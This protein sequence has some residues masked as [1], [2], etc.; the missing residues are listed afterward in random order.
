MTVATD[1]DDLQ[2]TLMIPGPIRLS[3]DV[4]NALG[5]PSISHTG[6]HFTKTF[7]SALLK[8]QKLFNVEEKEG[9]LP[10]VISSSGTMGWD[11]VGNNLL[12][13]SDTDCN[14]NALVLSTGFFSESFYLCLQSY[15]SNKSTVDKIV[16]P[17]G[18]SDFDEAELIAKLSS[19]KYRLV[20][21][22]HV[23]TSTA[24][25]V[26][27]NKV[28]K[29]IKDTSPSTF[30]VIDGVCS[31]GCEELDL[32]KLK[33]ID[34]VFTASQKAIGV[35]PGLC[36]GIISPR[37]VD[38]ILNENKNNIRGYYTNLTK[39]LPVMQS[40][41]K[42]QAKYFATPPVQLI[43]ALNVS[44]SGILK[45]GVTK[46]VEE[47]KSKSDWFKDKIVNDLKLKLV[48]QPG[49]G[50]H[51]LTAIYVN[52]PAELLKKIGADGIVLA[53]GIHKDI[54]DQYIRV[55]HMGVSI[56]NGDLEKVYEAL[57]KNVIQ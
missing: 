19:K 57:K 2:S 37:V 35:A 41:I 24:T 12:S 8:L 39:W 45:Q 26:D 15:A 4:Q 42:N 53:G 17:L 16:A 14:N 27:L 43:H 40:F 47:H 55:G 25:L 36:L 22:T 31:V 56:E 30:I 52:N 5:T 11:L 21:I 20:T 29:V 32:G 3:T 54:K 50:A 46:R 7:Q 49:Y 10:F 6:T 23:D 18:T 1:N 9:Y 33:G 34:F 44:L 28:V 13:S 51:G 48:S 38:F